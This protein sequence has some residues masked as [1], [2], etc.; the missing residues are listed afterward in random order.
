MWDQRYSAEGYVYGT[1][2]NGFLVAKADLLPA[3]AIL[4][5]GEGEGRNAVWLAT[6]GY[7]VTAV[8][9]SG[10]GLH[11]ARGLAAERGVRITTVH[12]DLAAFRSSREP[13]TGSSP[14]SVTCRP[15][16]G[17]RCTAAAWPGFGPAGSCCW[18]PTRP[19]GGAWDRRSA[20]GRADDGR[21]DLAHWSSPGWSSS[22]CMKPSGRSTRGPSTTGSAPWCN[23][24]PTG[25][26]RHAGATSLPQAR[27]MARIAR[28]L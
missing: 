8:D 23:W 25:L 21:G 18:R 2:P 3:G 5:L 26:E 20:H 22:S 10:V 17:P 14:S 4:C 27:R 13:G 1:E 16:C 15:R 28:R 12:A 24:W 19:A 11:K 7:E 6:Q 9:A